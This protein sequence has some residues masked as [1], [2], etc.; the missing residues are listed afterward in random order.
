MTNT[1][2]VLSFPCILTFGRILVLAIAF[3]F[4]I[5]SA[6]ADVLVLKQNQ[7]AGNNWSTASDFNNVASCTGGYRVVN[8]G[9]LLRTPQANSNQ[10]IL[11]IYL[12]YTYDVATGTYTVVG[13]EER[14]KM[15]LKNQGANT[16]TVEN[17]YLGNGQVLAW[18]EDKPT[19]AGKIYVEGNRSEINTQ[20]TPT[21]YLSSEIIKTTPDAC[22]DFVSYYKSGTLGEIWIRNSANVNCPLNLKQGKIVF[23]GTNTFGS[24]FALTLQ[25]GTS[26]IIGANYVGIEGTTI[27]VNGSA[28]YVHWQE[29]SANKVNYS[30]V[31]IPEGSTLNAQNNYDVGAK[32]S[33]VFAGDLQGSGALVVNTVGK[34]YTNSLTLGHPENSFTGTVSVQTGKLQFTVLGA[35]NVTYTGTNALINAA[36]VAVASGATIDVGSTTQTFNNFSG[37]GNVTTSDG[38]SLTLNNTSDTVFSGV[39]SGPTTLAKTGTGML[40]L[41][42]A[43]TYTGDTTVSDGTL[44]LPRNAKLNSLNVNVNGDGALVLGN[45]NNNG[46]NVNISERG[47]LVVGETSASQIITV[48]ALSLNGGKISLDLNDSANDDA[49]WLIVSSASL[50]SGIIDLT[51]NNDSETSWWNV[52][53]SYD[54][55]YSLIN[56]NISQ[57]ENM[58]VY[59]NG[60]PTTSW[61][62]YAR[63]SDVMLVAKDGGEAQWY[64]ANTSDISLNSWTIDGT[65][66]LG[67]KFTEGDNVATFAGGVALDDNGSFEIS[68]G[69]NLTLSGVVSGSGAMEKL[70]TGTLKM[71]GANTYTGMT[72]IS[73]GTLEIS[74][75]FTTSSGLAGSGT[76][77]LS[78]AGK[79][80]D[81]GDASGFTGTVQIFDDGISADSRVNLAGANGTASTNIDLSNAAVVIN[82]NKTSGKFSEIAFLKGNSTLKIGTLNGNEYGRILNTDNSTSTA[83][84]NNL[85]VGSGNYAGEIGRSTN[86]T[87]Y[88]YVNHINLTKANDGSETG[89]TL[90][91]SAKYLSYVGTTTIE[92]GTLEITNDLSGNAY[93]Y[94]AR[95][96]GL[97]GSGNLD[98]TGSNWTLFSL[99]GSNGSALQDF[100]GTIN[101][102]A[103][104][105]VTNEARSAARTLNLGN[106]T[107]NVKSNGLIG[108]HGI[109]NSAVSN[110]TV[111][112][113]N[114]EEG[115]RIRICSNDPG[116]AYGTLTAGRGL[117]SGT[118][119][120][121]NTVWNNVNLVKVSDGSETGG[122]LTIEGQ[123]YFVGSTTVSGGTLLL[124]GSLASPNVTVESGATFQTGS[125]IASTTVALNG[126]SFVL[127][128]TASSANIQTAGLTMT[129]D[130]AIYFDFNGY[131]DSADDYDKLFATSATLTSGTINLTFNNN[132]ETSWWEN[133]TD[134]GYVLIESS[135]L[136]ADLDNV[137][138]AIA[139]S[140]QNWRLE[141][142]G[143]NLVLMKVT[144]PE[145]PAEPY[146]YANSTDITADN[147]TI[148]GTD[149]KGVV[150]TEG[151]QTATFANPVILDADGSF[152]I[153]SGKNLTLSGV[154]S[155]EGG[156]EKLGAGTL[157][158]SGDNTYSGATSIEAGTLTLT[159]DAIKTNSSIEI[160]DDATLEYNVAANV[161][162]SLDFTAADA[163]VSGGNV[164]KTG[165]GTLKIFATDGQ[166]ESDLFA[167]E[168]GELDF[169][170]AYSGD[171]QVKA[172]ATLSPGNSVGELN[173]AG[174]VTI[175]EN[176]TILFEFSSYDDN[177]FDTLSIVN[178]DDEFTLSASSIVR[179]FFDGDASLWATEGATYQLV[180]DEGFASGVVDLSSLL[181]N[182]QTLF[183]LQGRTDGLYLIGLGAGPAPEPGSGVP[184]P[185]TWALLALGVVVLF[186]RKRVRG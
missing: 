26:L 174:N 165:A 31:L 35:D 110:L 20:D 120:E 129:N 68:E 46:N 50:K 8:S 1:R 175:D 40:T 180:S 65:N 7:A 34:N 89:G 146:Y 39:I 42:G 14:S 133:A 88:P 25:D 95:S 52:I 117:V 156:L 136:T 176:G 108:L 19:L 43:N 38:G 159:G 30:N 177:Q 114:V 67:A 113:L 27:T 127:G 98:F 48:G 162:K 83:T 161:T 119:G 151:G 63:Q 100:S 94:F 93:Q 147:W 107:L 130:G 11:A 92:G 6:Q 148:D 106:A 128:A 103:K 84:Y 82:G 140:A 149:K 115:G 101:A 64:Y 91:L 126:G 135:S 33:M 169:K 54:D 166:F 73:E 21:F 96:T 164:L 72:T 123:N 59:V 155:G 183:D 18:G 66:K 160:A 143:N 15:G 87:S 131:T 57:F 58:Q 16:I 184:E 55:G 86:N 182:Y 44:V 5:G 172:G 111:K 79:Q 105:M 53:K 178:A 41:S 121:E 144:P 56:G 28:R 97:K 167:V 81:I 10:S 153:G 29:T 173:V 163:T 75:N 122:T 124:T 45:A 141:T 99:D 12:G 22:L 24:D 71:T 85:I 47:N 145:P 2:P 3:L 168:A 109:Q 77:K 104:V 142:S 170:G 62:V 139:N 32:G 157:T 150:F 49:D 125:N 76:L 17:L 181:G 112:E 78:G 4:G 171:L 185:S 186:L 13:D 118:L 134:A 138:L 9:L 80:F 152:D 51:F 60:S 37:A 158:L 132:D 70:G 116:T 90:T 36:S 23:D 102:A 154:V 61:T 69:K 74:N 137:Q 179:L